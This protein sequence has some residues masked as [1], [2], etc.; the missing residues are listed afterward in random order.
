MRGASWVEH[1]AAYQETPL[2]A[3]IKLH[4]AARRDDAPHFQPLSSA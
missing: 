3:Y 4:T 2:N 1:Q